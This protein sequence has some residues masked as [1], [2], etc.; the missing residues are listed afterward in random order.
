[1]EIQSSSDA[2]AFPPKKGRGCMFYGCLSVI[3][4][5][6]LA[7]AAIYFGVNYFVSHV[8]DQY[9]MTEPIALPKVAASEESYKVEKQR[10]DDFIQAVKTGQGAA[11][12][13]FT[14]DQLNTL[15][16]FYPELKEFRDHIFITIKDD[17]LGGKVSYPL[18]KLGFAGRFLNGEATA[19][20]KLENGVLEIFLRSFSVK[21]APVSDAFLKKISSQNLAGKLYED[22]K[23]IEVVKKLESVA[24]HDGKIVIKR[25]A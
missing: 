1:M 11:E 18:D 15:V 3:I 12:I 6:V 13:S 4:F 14:Q 8:I 19:A 21:G 10:L 5:F 22:P 20:V 24:I 16:N 23:Y 17:Q 25:K 2:P 7:T 9:T